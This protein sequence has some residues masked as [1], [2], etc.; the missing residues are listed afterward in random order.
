VAR[1]RDRWRSAF[2]LTNV[3]RPG[4]TG[5]ELGG[6]AARARVIETH[7]FV[8]GPDQAVW[9]KM[10]VT[11]EAP[12]GRRSRIECWL[13]EDGHRLLHSAR[14]VPVRVDDSGA[15]LGV[16]VDAY[17]AEAAAHLASLEARDS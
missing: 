17:E 7:S 14:T 6:V 10:A 5:D 13:S 16:D 9:A 4:P 11:V 8:S 1:L 3:P 12:D 2:D 15:V